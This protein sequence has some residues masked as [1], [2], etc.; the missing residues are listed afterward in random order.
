[1][2]L[3]KFPEWTN[4][5]LS[6]QTLLFF[7]CHVQRVLRLALSRVYSGTTQLNSTRRR[8]EL[9]WVELSRYKPGFRPTCRLSVGMVRGGGWDVLHCFCPRGAQKNR[10]LNIDQYL[11]TLLKSIVAFY[12]SQCVVKVTFFLRHPVMLYIC[13][14]SATYSTVALW[15][16]HRQRRLIFA[17]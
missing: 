11:E 14:C 12:D 17:Q 15:F 16:C 9:S 10:S 8:V 6:Q 1:M 13:V 4:S 5:S 7:D 3:I 2:S